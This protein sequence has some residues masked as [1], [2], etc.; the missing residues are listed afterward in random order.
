MIVKAWSAG[1][2]Y[3]VYSLHEAMGTGPHVEIT[4][5][6]AAR[7]DAAYAEWQ[8]VQDVIGGL[9][10]FHPKESGERYYPLKDGPHGAHA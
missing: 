10:V 4:E 6:L 1:E 2:W 9:A 8:A 7:Y 3:P 5:E